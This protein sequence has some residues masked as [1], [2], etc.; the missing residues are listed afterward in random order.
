MANAEIKLWV[1]Y[2][3]VSKTEADAVATHVGAKTVLQDSLYKVVSED[4]NL[5]QRAR[6]FG[7]GFQAA[8]DVVQRAVDKN[9]DRTK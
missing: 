8:C 5:I 3:T 1:L 2:E 7:A 9:W 6:D 4:H